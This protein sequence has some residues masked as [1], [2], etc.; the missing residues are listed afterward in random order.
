[1]PMYEDKYQLTREYEKKGYKDLGKLGWN[2]KATNAYCQS[3]DKQEYPI[4]RNYD[5]IVMHDLKAFCTVD[6]SD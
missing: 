3:K 6:S 2:E 1:M 5:L 4:G